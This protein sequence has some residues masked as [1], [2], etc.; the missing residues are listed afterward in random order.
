M[1]S[2]DSTPVMFWTLVR[3]QVVAYIQTVKAS[4]GDGVI[5]F[6]EARAL[7]YAGTFAIMKIAKAMPVNGE[8]K[9]EFVIESAELLFDALA[10]YIRIPYVNAFV[11]SFVRSYIMA[12]VRAGIR[13]TLT[14]LIDKLYEETKTLLKD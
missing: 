7:V 9:K 11:P 12:Q 10:P 1:S 2:A 6:A 14:V 13:P 3:E 4:L 5:T 8:S